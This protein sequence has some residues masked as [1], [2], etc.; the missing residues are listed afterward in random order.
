MILGTRPE[1]I[2]L[3]PVVHA[4]EGTPGVTCSVVS[5]GQH[6]RLLDQA[7]ELFGIQADVESDTI[8]PEPSNSAT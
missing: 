3:A 7:L 2:K 6:R 5:T 4:L 8:L 1:A